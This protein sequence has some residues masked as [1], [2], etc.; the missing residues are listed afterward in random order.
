M[1]NGLAKHQEHGYKNKDARSQ[2][3]PTNTNTSETA[4]R[5]SPKLTGA[6]ELWPY[7]DVLN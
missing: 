1:G 7:L 2:W 4:E 6:L 3:D 5:E